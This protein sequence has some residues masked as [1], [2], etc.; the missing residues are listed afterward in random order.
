MFWAN[1]KS[2]VVAKRVVPDAERETTATPS[3]V[4]PPHVQ[5]EHVPT[6]PHTP[7]R[8]HHVTQHMPD[9]TTHRPHRATHHQRRTTT[10]TTTTEM[11]KSVH[12]SKLDPNEKLDEK[13]LAVLYKNELEIV[14]TRGGH[15]DDEADRVQNGRSHKN[16][17]FHPAA[18]SL[19]NQST[20]Q[21]ERGTVYGVTEVDSSVLHQFSKLTTFPFLVL[22]DNPRR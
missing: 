2:T 12:H 19:I 11:P 16:E 15:R 13:E 18:H 1:V 10:T 20:S 17:N 6:T 5:P 8:I 22:F 21:D 4:H 9:H 3:I 14:K 7:K